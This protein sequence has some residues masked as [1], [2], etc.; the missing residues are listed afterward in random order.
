MPLSP[1]ADLDLDA[2]TLLEI[3]S[4]AE[5]EFPRECCGYLQRSADGSWRCTPCQNQ[6]DKLHRL[7]PDRYPRDATSAYEIGGAELLAMVRSFESAAPVR[8]IYHSHPVGGAYFS[9]TDRQGAIGSAYPVDYLVVDV[10]QG[11]AREARLFASPAARNPFEELAR[12]D[13]QGQRIPHAGGESK[14]E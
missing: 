7:D 9:Q 3:Y 4:Q 14:P 1:A 6:Q 10:A 8:I 13:T 2:Q 11:Q 5:R 12:Y